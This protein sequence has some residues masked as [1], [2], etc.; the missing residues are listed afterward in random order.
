MAKVRGDLRWETR[1][2]EFSSLNTRDAETNTL[3]TEITQVSNMSFEELG[4]LKKINGN[5][6]VTNYNFSDFSS[7]NKTVQYTYTE[8]GT[9]TINLEPTATNIVIQELILIGGG[10]GGGGGGVDLGGFLYGGGG[11]GGGAGYRSQQYSLAASGSTYTIVVGAGGAKG[12]TGAGPSYRGTSG[13]AGEASTLTYGAT[14]ITENGGGG[15]GGGGSGGAG[16]A[17][18]AG[19]NAGTAGSI[20]ATAGNGG[21]GATPQFG[22]TGENGT[23]YNG[24]GN[25]G[26]YAGG[27][28]GGGG[29]NEYPSTRLAGNGGAGYA[30]IRIN[31]DY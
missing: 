18:G 20:D 2:K 25:G 7:T 1:A 17:G 9:Y 13:T 21:T 23:V 22:T 8:A 14:V 29:D 19:E 6:E 4:A 31:Y 27:G 3:V 16:G 30:Y 12:V 11:G 28:G 15:G 24:G 10:G 26:S 5:E